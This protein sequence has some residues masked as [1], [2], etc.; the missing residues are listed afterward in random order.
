[1]NIDGMTDHTNPP[2]SWEHK[3]FG[4]D[5]QGLRSSDLASL[6]I[7]ALDGDLPFP[8][9]TLNSEAVSHNVA[10]MAQFCADHDV[11][12]APHAK[13]TMSPELV[14]RQL[15][16]GAWG[17][18][19]ATVAQA[20]ILREFGVESIIIASQVLDPA[21]IRWICDEQE[22]DPDFFVATLVDS[23]ESVQLMER[24]IARVSPNSSIRVLVELGYD[25][26]RAGTRTLDQALDVAR[27]A[28]HAQS[29]VLTGVEGFE[30]MMPGTSVA[31]RRISVDSYLASARVF[32]EICLAEHLF[33]N[34]SAKAPLPLVTFGGS[35]FHDL[36][37]R[38]FAGR[39]ATSNGVRV[40]LR[41]GCYIT[42]D[43]GLYAETSP[44][45]D[46]P[47]TLRAAAEVWGVVLS[48]PEPGRAILGF[49]RRDV[50]SDAGFPKVLLRRRDGS[51][52][53]ARKLTITA[54]NDQ[55][56]Y[57]DLPA[58]FDLQVGDL[59]G[60]GISHP[61]TTFDK[62]SLIPEVDANYRV[63]GSVHTFF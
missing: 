12:L 45:A 6:G 25:N 43:H 15:G 59:L 17:M 29:L 62:W 9:M 21:G 55:H 38:E 44:W 60:C 50:G 37:V 35:A 22:D 52:Q 41:S 8:L 20:R 56:A 2:I 23:V 30:G 19:A 51:N 24:L 33:E 4:A 27:A 34:T 18:T 28:S 26:G 48:L 10:V 46:G 57:V 32:T 1:M 14:R 63:V 13:T 31:A 40:V 42:H 36:V 39:W 61:C 16:A 47:R 53:P 58:D 49:G 54:L 5:L 7:S 11:D 3:A